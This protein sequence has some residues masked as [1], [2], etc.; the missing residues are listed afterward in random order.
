MPTVNINKLIMFNS[1]IK[2]T[3]QNMFF[4]WQV[5]PW[6]VQTLVKEFH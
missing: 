1:G 6:L 4:T 3:K 2:K 5:R